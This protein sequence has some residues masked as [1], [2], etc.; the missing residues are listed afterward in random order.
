MIQ[1]ITDM[2]ISVYYIAEFYLAGNNEVHYI[3]NIMSIND[4]VHSM[5]YTTDIKAALHMSEMD[6]IILDKCLKETHTWNG[7]YDIK[8]RRRISID[9]SDDYN[10]SGI[11]NNMTT[12]DSIDIS[13]VT[14]PPTLIYGWDDLSKVPDSHTHKIDIRDPKDCSGYIVSKFEDHHF[15]YL[16]THTFYGYNCNMYAESTKM[17]QDCGFNIVLDNWDKKEDDIIEPETEDTNYDVDI[18]NLSIDNVLSK[19][20]DSIYPVDVDKTV[21]INSAKPSITMEKWSYYDV[22]GDKKTMDVFITKN[23]N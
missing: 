14:E 3:K 9:I 2:D 23:N 13:L 20:G 19:L 16:S 7:M 5:E 12:S 21:L 10:R 6:S 4:T 11:T 8:F 22:N 15:N 17:L 18:M 1:K